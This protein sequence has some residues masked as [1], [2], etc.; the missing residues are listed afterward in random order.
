MRKIWL[1]NVTAAVL[2][3]AGIAIACAGHDTL[4]WSPPPL[5]PPWAAVSGRRV[6]EPPA[7]LARRGRDGRRLP[8]PLPRSRPVR[9]DIPAIGVRA[10]VIPLGLNRNGSVAVPPLS[11]PFL[12]GWYDRG[13]APGERGAAV[14]LGHAD[15]RSVGPAVFYD[16]GDLRPGDRILVRLAGGRTAAF[17]VSSVALYLNT[18]FPTD[19]VYGYT[20]WPTLRLITCGGTF[21]PRTGHYLGNIVVFA[22]YAGQRPAAPAPAQLPAGLGKFARIRSQG[23]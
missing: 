15:A 12:A 13:P 7:A 22:S 23:R 10:R 18:A 9:I 14:L 1:L 6:N 3:G 20:A 5:P 19:R 21:D 16:L 11:T 8:A 2:M 4:R 17:G